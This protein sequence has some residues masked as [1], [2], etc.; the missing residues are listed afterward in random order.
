MPTPELQTLVWAERMLYRLQETTKDERT[1][2]VALSIR[3]SMRPHTNPRIA[4]LAQEYD[5]EH[6]RQERRTHHPSKKE[7]R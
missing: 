4:H 6:A 7:E 1:R 2:S 3:M 5:E